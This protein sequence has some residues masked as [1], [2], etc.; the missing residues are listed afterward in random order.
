MYPELFRIGSRSIPSFYIAVFVGAL[1]AFLLAIYL[2]RKRKLDQIEFISYG[3]FLIISFWLGSIIYKLVLKTIQDPV[4]FLEGL[5]HLKTLVIESGTSVVGG[6]LGA[7]LFSLIYLRR[8]ELPF[9]PTLDIA[10]TVI[11]LGQAVGRVGCFLAGCCYGRPT[12]LFWGVKFPGHPSPVHPTQLYE[13]GLNF[14]NF[15]FL[16]RLLKRQKFGGQN[17]AF[18]LMNYSIIRFVVEYWRGDDYRGFLI[19]GST[20]WASLSIPQFMCLIGFAAGFLIW[21]YRRRQTS[22]EPVQAR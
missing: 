1:L 10:F 19:T 13:S 8:V 4:G 6:I 15:V 21:L 16:I 2:S 7:G 3:I 20:P 11:P 17:I 12:D 5:F 14:L 9:W 18:Y 22:Q